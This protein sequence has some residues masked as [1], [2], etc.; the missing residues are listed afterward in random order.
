MALEF[1]GKLWMDLKAFP[2]PT[3]HSLQFLPCRSLPCMC[4]LQC[5]FCAALTEPDIQHA[6]NYVACLEILEVNCTKKLVLATCSKFL[7]SFICPF[8]STVSHSVNNGINIPSSI[9]R[10]IRQNPCGQ[11][12]YGN[13]GPMLVPCRHAG[14]VYNSF[15]IV[16]PNHSS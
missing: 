11:D 3:Q 2:P 16:T 13:T 1:D 7:C 8:V 4:R 5:R 14:R 6:L 15:Q 9:S 12:L 10:G